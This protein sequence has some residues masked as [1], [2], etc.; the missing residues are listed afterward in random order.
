MKR[1]IAIGT[2]NEVSAYEPYNLNQIVGSTCLQMWFHWL[3]YLIEMRGTIKD[4]S[5]TLNFKEAIYF[6]T[7]T[8]TVALNVLTIFNS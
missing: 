7:T 3:L 5:L 4:V 8:I 6:I 2:T 1:V